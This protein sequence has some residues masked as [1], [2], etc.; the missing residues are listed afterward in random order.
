MKKKAKT[1]QPMS[2][3]EARMLG[4]ICSLESDNYSTSEGWIMID[5]PEVTLSKQRIGE[6]RTGKVTFSRAAFKRMIDWYLRPQ[7]RR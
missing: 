2:P 1:L 7:Q 5:G 6:E 4:E 3:H